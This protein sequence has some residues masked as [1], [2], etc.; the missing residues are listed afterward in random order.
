[1]S[2]ESTNAYAP[3]KITNEI[4]STV[5]VK[6]DSS[7]ALSFYSSALRNVSYRFSKAGIATKLRYA[8]RQEIACRG[9]QYL[10]P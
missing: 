3:V 6:H 9:E 7:E 5:S 1:M 10:P 4:L 2:H 8:I